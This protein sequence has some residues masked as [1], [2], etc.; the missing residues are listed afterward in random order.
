M[1]C[2]YCQSLQNTII[3][4][5]VQS[6]RIGRLRKCVDCDRAFQTSERVKEEARS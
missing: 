4:S 5:I 2:P 3:D 1:R 6:D